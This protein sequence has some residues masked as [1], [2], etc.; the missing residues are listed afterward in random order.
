[1]ADGIRRSYTIA[2]LADAIEHSDLIVY[3]HVGSLP[4]NL[5]TS[6]VRLLGSGAGGWRYTA[7][8][9]DEA[10]LPPGRLQMLGHEMQHA[11]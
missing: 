4:D 10:L 8:W 7:L 11:V 2:R 1:M 3:V 9:I 6:Q 5:S